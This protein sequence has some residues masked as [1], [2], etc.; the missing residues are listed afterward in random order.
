VFNARCLVRGS[1]NR[2]RKF[3]PKARVMYLESRREKKHMTQVW[4]CYA[5]C[6]W[7][8]ATSFRRGPTWPFGKHHVDGGVWNAWVCACASHTRPTRG[9]GR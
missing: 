1:V 6:E 3:A 5:R 7:A 8:R 9:T 2:P 4:T